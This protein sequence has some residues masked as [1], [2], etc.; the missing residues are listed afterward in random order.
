MPLSG[1]RLFYLEFYMRIRTKWSVC[2]RPGNEVQAVPP[3]D[4]SV[5]QI[6]Q[7]ISVEQF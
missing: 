6:D 7:P 5:T 1:L 4:L 3:D 2:D